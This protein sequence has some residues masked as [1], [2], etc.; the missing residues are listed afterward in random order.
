M[1]SWS[2]EHHGKFVIIIPLGGTHSKWPWAWALVSPLGEEHRSSWAPSL[3]LF[4]NGDVASLGVNFGKQIYISPCALYLSC[5]LFACET[6]FL[7]LEFD[8]LIYKL[9]A[10]TSC[11][12]TLR[13]NTWYLQIYSVKISCTCT[14]VCHWNFIPGHSGY[15]IQKLWTSSS[16]Y[17]DI[18]PE[19]RTFGL[20]TVW[21]VF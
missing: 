17:P 10:W 12:E 19:Y 18:Y 11:W 5:H 2:C 9:L 1:L 21:Q 4:L 15:N 8:L 7:G 16:E 13:R 14:V 20:P 6:N 3:E